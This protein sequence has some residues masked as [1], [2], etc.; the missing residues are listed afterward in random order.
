MEEVLSKFKYY[1]ILLLAVVM[2]L[3]FFNQ[4]S[5]IR[6]VV[7]D[8][9]ESR[10][11][12]VERNILETV[13]YI[14]DTYKI[15]EKQLNQE[16]L[17][18]SE[19]ML[20]KYKKNPEIKNWDLEKMK[21]QFPGYDIY[22][23]DQNLKVIKTTFK[24][25]FGLDFSKFGSFAKVLR[26]RMAASKFEVDRIDLST[27]TGEIKKYSYMPSPDGKY[28]FELSVSIE[29]HYP[30]LQSLNLF[31]DAT[32]LTAE[33][34]LVKNISFYSVEPSR[35]GVAKIRASKK[36]YLN[37]DVP[38]IEE[39]LARQ[40]VIQNSIQIKELNNENENLRYR[41]FPALVADQ[42]NQQGWNSYVVGIIYDDRV[43]I[44]EIEKYKGLFIFNSLLLTVLFSAF[45]TFIIYL[46]KKF[47]HQAYHDKLTGLANRKYFAEKFEKL[48]QKANF[49]ENNIGLIFIDINKFKEINDTY[50][51]DIGDKVL[52]NIAAKMKNNLK[53]E[54]LVA[55]LGGDEFLIA[56]SNLDSKEKIIKVA[57]RLVK[58][59]NGLLV[60]NEEKIEISVSSG[61]SF[62]PEDS[63]DLEK[64]IKNADSAMYKAKRKNKSLEI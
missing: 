46:L 17:E 33:Y 44:E 56:L 52:E 51:H 14:N 4:Y 59:L 38:E 25:D 2:I 19:Q 20:A 15:V 61:I 53:E 9:Y 60:I 1:I 50:G 62:Y 10:Q 16:M 47:E 27:Q 23:I 21:A 43:K 48:K 40:A 13:G 22:I 5:N 6:E 18:Y 26:A 54:D 12:L 35:H 58:K 41:F 36:P 64:L 31:K 57:K 30:S 37:P 3:I 34:E 8:K 55:R 45:I 42:D 29:D 28:L 7:E 32:A 24:E 11:Q 39:E 49:N 63:S